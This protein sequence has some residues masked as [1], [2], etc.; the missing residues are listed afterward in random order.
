MVRWVTQGEQSEQCQRL[1]WYR[2]DSVRETIE[3]CFTDGGHNASVCTV[4]GRRRNM[5]AELHWPACVTDSESDSGQFSRH[6]C[7]YR[8]YWHGIVSL[9]LLALHA[10]QHGATSPAVQCPALPTSRKLNSLSVM[11]QA[12]TNSNTLISVW[13][14]V[15]NDEILDIYGYIKWLY[16]FGQNIWS[17]V[18]QLLKLIS[19]ISAPWS[20][21]LIVFLR[22]RKFLRAVNET[23]LW[24]SVLEPVD[25]RKVKKWRIKKGIAGQWG[26]TCPLLAS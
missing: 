25:Q 10:V 20:H 24:L 18:W 1:G 22:F 5:I 9:R 19:F 16:K 8:I 26:R 15:D 12:Y 13:K 6:F 3:A 17:I 4:R 23:S 7:G 14:T 2:V 21:L 11:M